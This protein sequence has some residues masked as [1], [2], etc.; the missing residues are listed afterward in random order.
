[1]SVTVV[2][3]TGRAKS[4]QIT[5]AS[6]IDVYS[7]LPAAAAVPQGTHAFALDL[8]VELVAYGGT[9]RGIAGAVPISAQLPYAGSNDP[10]D[11]GG[12]IT[13]LLADGRLIDRTVY[14][15]FF[16]AVGHRYNGGVDPGSSHVRLP[17]KRGR[18]SVGADNMGTAQGAASRIP[19]SNRAA[20]QNGGEERHTLLAA[21]SGVNGSGGTGNDTPDHVHGYQAAVTV[22]TIDGGS[23]ANVANQFGST[24]GGANTRHTHPLVART[25]DA[26]HN[27]MQPYEVDNFIVRV[28]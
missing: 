19:N 24:T 22:A 14:V 15:A 12:G 10:G 13:F 4:S 3:G 28:A 5:A 2:D 1:V 17:D 9:W 25:A 21:E 16:T 26:P 20:G 7:A 11:I 6:L 18:A 23:T 8:G 27:V